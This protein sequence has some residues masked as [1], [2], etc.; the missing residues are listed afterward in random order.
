MTR[1]AN[2]LVEAGLKETPGWKQAQAQQQAMR[3]GE[4]VTQYTTR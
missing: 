3:I 1:L 4:G 2:D